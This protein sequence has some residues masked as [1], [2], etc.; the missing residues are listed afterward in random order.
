MFSQSTFPASVPQTTYISTHKRALI[1]RILLMAGIALSVISLVFSILQYVFPELIDFEAETP[2]VATIAVALLVTGLAL[3]EIAVYIATIVLFLM[4][5]YR[6]FENLP[7]FGV[8]RNSIK[9]SPGWAAGSFFIPFVSLI[10]P[11]RAVKELW[12]KSVPNSGTMFGDQSPP[13]FFP[14]WWAAWLLS[15]IT[16]NAY[17]RLSF[18]DRLSSEADAIMG[19][20]T[21][22]LSIVAAF[23]AIKVVNE[24]DKQQIESSG[25]MPHQFVTQS[26][27]LPEQFLNE[28]VA[29][30]PPSWQRESS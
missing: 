8:P 16:S 24:I 12:N 29:T 2:G 30:Q 1:V 25:L 19:A 10:V 22:A 17:L 9:H 28:A 3:L 13:A 26:P 23:F 4:W 27:P 21:A 7:A 15:N 5:L 18:S 14:I 20:V 11:Y 6:S